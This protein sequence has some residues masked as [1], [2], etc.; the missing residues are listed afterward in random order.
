MNY[1]WAICS[2]TLIFLPIKKEWK[3][4]I[5]KKQQYIFCANHFSY[6]DIPA[7]GLTPVPF[8]FVGKSSLG[9]IPLFGF[10][11]NRLHITVNRS[12]YRSR[13]LSLQKAREEL[14]HGFNLGFFPEG[15]IRLKEYPEMADFKDGAFKLSAEN[16]V[17]II[18]VTLPDNFFILNDDDLLNIRRKKCRIIYHTPIWPDRDCDDAARKL[19]DDVFRVIQA[20]LIEVQS[21]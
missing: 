13:A 14:N 18:P 10:M 9:K 2:T 1:L 3:F 16:N 15:G 4:K 19:K 17:P 11:Y 6:L 21:S 5:D 20:E 7:M 12:S 8:K